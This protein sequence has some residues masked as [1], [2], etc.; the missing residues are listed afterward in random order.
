M[1]SERS[2]TPILSQW[3]SHT[4]AGS[5]LV[6]M[7]LCLVPCAFC[8]G[9]TDTRALSDAFRSFG[10]S[11][12]L[13]AWAWTQGEPAVIAGGVLAAQGYW[14]WY[15]FCMAAAIPSA[16][17]HEIYY[18]LGRRYGGRVLAWFPRRWQPAIDRT[19][20]LLIRHERKI[21]A[22]MRFAYGVR[23]PLP[24][25]CGTVGT[26]PLRFFLFNLGTA[27]VWAFVF[28]LIGYAF[29]AT[30][31]VLF[32]SVSRFE[33]WILI[34]SLIFGVCLQVLGQKWAKRTILK[35]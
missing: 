5:S 15:G 11:P 26:R 9:G 34:G 14:P 10:W 6:W 13:L 28:T 17:G 30:A 7:A 8:S 1:A 12:L 19:R 33:A 3:I 2:I 29:G 23:G 24:A 31:T 27:L 25:V 21:L 35:A 18:Y 4:L 22:L 20:A 32:E 16:I